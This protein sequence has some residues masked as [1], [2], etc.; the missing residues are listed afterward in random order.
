MRKF[1]INSDTSA[2]AS[3]P[4]INYVILVSRQSAGQTLQ[5]QKN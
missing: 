4:K 1:S 3:Y 2:P 5:Q